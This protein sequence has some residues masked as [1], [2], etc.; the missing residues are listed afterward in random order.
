MSRKEIVS[1]GNSGYFIE[2]LRIV[3]GTIL[4]FSMVFFHACNSKQGIE[5]SWDFE[6]FFDEEP[7]LGTLKLE[8]ENDSIVGV[9]HSFIMGKMELENLK[10][11]ND[12]LNANF[13]K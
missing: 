9:I 2:F 4:V 1:I 12:E 6:I 3:I 8:K 10:I 5:G 7:I 13:E 11:V